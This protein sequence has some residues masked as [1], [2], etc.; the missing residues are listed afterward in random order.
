MLLFRTGKVQW[1]QARKGMRRLEV[2]KTEVGSGIVGL[3]RMGTSCIETGER[4]GK[5][6]LVIH[7]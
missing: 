3:E 2:M 1:T 4:E 6:E 7:R 5:L